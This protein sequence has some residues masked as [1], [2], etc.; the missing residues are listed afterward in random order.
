MTWPDLIADGGIVITAQDRQALAEA[1][2]DI[3]K[4]IYA[5]ET[6]IPL[7]KMTVVLGEDA[8][9]DCPADMTAAQCNPA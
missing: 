9:Q 7:S 4:L 2:R 1:E 5:D 6:L 8:L 3:Q